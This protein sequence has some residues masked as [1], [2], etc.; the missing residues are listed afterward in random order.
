MG[1]FDDDE[2]IESRWHATK[3][4]RVVKKIDTGNAVRFGRFLR[5]K[6]NLPGFKRKKVFY[7]LNTNA[8]LQSAIKAGYWTNVNTRGKK[9]YNLTKQQKQIVA[10]LGGSIKGI[11]EWI[12]HISN[13]SNDVSSHLIAEEMLRKT[14]EKVNYND[15]TGNLSGAFYA[16]SVRNNRV[17]SY[18]YL[19]E[20]TFN[21]HSGQYF[22]KGRKRAAKLQNIRHKTNINGK[23]LR[24][25]GK[26][27]K[28]GKKTSKNIRY[29][30]KWE[31]S[32]GYKNKGAIKKRGQIPFKTY[33]QN[34]KRKKM[35]QTG[36]IIGNSSPYAGLLGHYRVIQ[37][38]VLRANRQY[39]NKYQKEAFLNL[40]KKNIE[41]IMKLAGVNK[42]I[43]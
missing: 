24:R 14:F 8:G 26:S 7:D 3:G 18:Y 4:A 31:I 23:S 30:Q 13:A 25:S 19:D 43:W 38:A 20:E 37:G 34:G 1:R 41:A 17:V 28:Y 11:G 36:I 22:K 10:I 42:V 5:T 16:Y 40:G 6:Q 21:F 27:T 9:G 2:I 32:K 39:W 35:Y 15:Y 33:T 12:G 29:L